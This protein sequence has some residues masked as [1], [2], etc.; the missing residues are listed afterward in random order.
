MSSNVDISWVAILVAAIVNMV[1]GAL[2]Y[3]PGVFGGTWMELM[4]KKKDDMK[5]SPG[6]LAGMF[7]VALAIGYIFTHFISYAGVTTFI[8]GMATG[9]WAGLGFTVLTSASGTFASGTSWKLWAINGGYWLVS[10]SIM[11]GILATIK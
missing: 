6:P 2:W 4:G 1:L 7:V 11:G 5:P 10:L 9:L 3:S 8:G